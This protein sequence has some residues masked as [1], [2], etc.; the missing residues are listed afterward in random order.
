LSRVSVARE[1]AEGL[2]TEIPIR[3]LKMIRDF[4]EVC[5]KGRPLSPAAQAFREFLK[6]K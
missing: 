3:E 5:Y 1:L 2:L 4:Y 6:N